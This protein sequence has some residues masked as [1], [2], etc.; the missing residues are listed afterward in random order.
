MISV[1]A[2]SIISALISF[3]SLKKYVFKVDGSI[4]KF[5]IATTLM[6][7]FVGLLSEILF[8]LVNSISPLS[9]YLKKRLVFYK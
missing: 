9:F 3:H 6:I 4:Y 2:A 1:Y 8:F 5:Y 7:C